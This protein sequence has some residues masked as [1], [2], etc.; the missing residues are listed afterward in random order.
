M[1]RT[2]SNPSLINYNIKLGSEPS[3]GG[4]IQISDPIGVPHEHK[5][6]QHRPDEDQTQSRNAD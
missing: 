4:L 1:S 5:L 3:S 2:D 6:C